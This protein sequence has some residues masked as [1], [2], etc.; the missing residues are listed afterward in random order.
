MYVNEMFSQSP[1]LISTQENF[2][3]CRPLSDA[4]R[5]VKETASAHYN[6]ILAENKFDPIRFHNYWGKGHIIVFLSMAR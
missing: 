2:S 5:G 3:S 4:P 6:A 1:I